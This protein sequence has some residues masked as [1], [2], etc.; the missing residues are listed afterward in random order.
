MKGIF[1]FL[2]LLCCVYQNFPFVNY[3]GEIGR[4]PVILLTP[5]FL[6]YL[7]FKRSISLSIYSRVYISYITYLLIISC[8]YI[9]FVY[10]QIGEFSFLEE[11]IIIKSLKMVVYPMTSLLLYF[12]FTEFLKKTG[13]LR[14]LHRS[15]YVLLC[16][17]LVLLFYE[18]KYYKTEDA[19]MPYLHSD[20]LKYWRIR[21]LTM[22]SSWAGSVVII[23]SL[24]N[25]FLA[26]Y[27]NYQK[28]FKYVCYFFSIFFLVYYTIHSESKGFLL[29]LLF[30]FLPMLISL[31]KKYKIL[32]WYLLLSIVPLGFL[33]GF[34]YNYLYFEIQSN[35]FVHGTFGTRITGYLS[36]LEVFL[37]NPFGVGLG[38][39]VFVYTNHIENVINYDFMASLDLG[40][41]SGYLNSTKFLS[42]K[43]YF[44]DHLIFGGVGF[45]F[46]FWMFFIKR[47]ISIRK[48]PH[49]PILRI[50]LV[51]ILLSGVFYITY[52]VKYDVW[53]FFAVLD[54]L[55]RKQEC[56]K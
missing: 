50:G 11:N 2:V 1:L 46:F 18:I 42:T 37:F 56:L 26:N 36:S 45:I 9:V 51:F 12:F 47:Y 30:A 8:L 31:Y 28:W 54:A 32:R 44:F 52:G 24:L 21:L 5:F 17:L 7:S 13:R 14:I 16:F 6:V 43:T 53:M 23:I 49:F 48:I 34:V 25:V 22:E 38:P 41:V 35:F 39:Y 55:E 10:I 19:F 4:S 33:T 20:G 29:L 3:V 27:L 15:I 40:E